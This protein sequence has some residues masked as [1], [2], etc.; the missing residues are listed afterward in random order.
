MS[1]QTGFEKTAAL[2]TML[3]KAYGAA[4]G[5]VTSAQRAASKGWGSFSGG[6]SQATRTGLAKTVANRQAA[7]GVVQGP[8]PTDVAKRYIQMQQHVQS[9]GK[10]KFFGKHPGA[11][12]LVGG[13]VLGATMFGGGGSNQMQ[14]PQMTGYAPGNY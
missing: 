3:G 10:N 1:F 9:S 11:K 13:G 2:G 5:V 4:R 12:Y 6:S 7:R 14:Q 8:A